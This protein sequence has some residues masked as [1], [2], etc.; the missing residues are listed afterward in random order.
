[1][2]ARRAEG[3]LNSEIPGSSSKTGAVPR[4]RLNGKVAGEFGGDLLIGG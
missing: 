1:M 3:A 4:L 2:V